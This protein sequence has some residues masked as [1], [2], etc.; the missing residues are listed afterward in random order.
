MGGGALTAAKWVRG[1]TGSEP[2]CAGP[3]RNYRFGVP[4][5]PLPETQLPAGRYPA[6]TSTV[7]LVSILVLVTE[8]VLVFGIPGP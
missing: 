3:L 7:W 5:N 2:R 6:T 4:T 8:A 1:R